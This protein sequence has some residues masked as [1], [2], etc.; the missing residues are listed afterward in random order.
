MVSML[1]PIACLK[2]SLG[3]CTP[4]DYIEV[5]GYRLHTLIT[6]MSSTLA[7]EGWHL[8]WGGMALVSEVWGEEGIDY[9]DMTV[10]GL[11]LS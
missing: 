9:L 5:F 1:F 6:R 2:L 10:M 8:L 3:N 11:F 7:G 4:N